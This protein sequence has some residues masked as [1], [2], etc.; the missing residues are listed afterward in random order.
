ML[1]W[2]RD[3]QM[4]GKIY[5]EVTS[6]NINVFAAKQKVASFVLPLE[7]NT[8]YNGKSGVL[9]ANVRQTAIRIVDITCKPAQGKWGLL[10]QRTRKMEPISQWDLVKSVFPIGDKMNENTHIFDGSVFTNKD[11]TM[12]Y[13]MTALP[14]NV[15][16]EIAEA[17]V[18]LFG[19]PYRLKCLDTVENILFHQYAK[20]GT[21]ALWVIFPQDDGLRV[22]FL[23]DGLPRAA[24]YVS[25]NPQFRE[26]EVLRCLR[27]SVQPVEVQDAGCAKEIKETAL[28]RAAVLNTG[29]DLEWLCTLLAEQDVEVEQR[30]YCLMDFIG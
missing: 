10:L 16:D 30:E 2:Q 3:I 25:N 5:A 8:T 19:G 20:H 15:A 21:E 29:W 22:L 12:R 11:G 7:E 6:K 13:F 17:G 28:K 27:A 18:K 14:M 26:D 9:I 23:T 24:W 4:M 1:N